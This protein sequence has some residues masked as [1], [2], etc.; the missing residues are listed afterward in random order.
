[1]EEQSG[2]YVLA[3]EEGDA[4]WFAGALMILKATG[5]QTTG[6]FALLDQRAPEDYAVPLHVHDRE[7]E[8]WYI[9]EGQV[10]FSCGDKTFTAGPGAWVFAPKG[11]PHAFRVGPT[12]ARLL[13]MAWPAGFAD[14]VRVAGEPAPALT[15]P[16]P[17]P[18]DVERLTELGCQYGIQIVGPPPA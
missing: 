18:L 11:V 12:D 9:L 13:T 3:Q 10:T 8:G 1:M 17:A 14:F 5:E 15:L 16:E 2:A 4:I 7:D 6:Q